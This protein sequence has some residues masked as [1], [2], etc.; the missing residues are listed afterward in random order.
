MKKLLAFVSILTLPLISFVSE[1]DLVIPDAVKDQ[2]VLYWGFLIT[3]LGMGFGFYQFLRVKGIGAHKSMLDVAQVIYE[4][5]KTYLV[6]QGKFLALLFIFIGAAVAFYFGYLSE[7]NFGVGG[8]I[9]ILDGQLLEF[10][11]LML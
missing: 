11:V 9:M 6:Q 7:A 1:A 10:L 8:V 4:T 2:T 5:G 3:I